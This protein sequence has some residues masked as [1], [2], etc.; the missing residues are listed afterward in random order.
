MLFNLSSFYRFFVT[1]R[2]LPLSKPSETVANALL[3]NK[4][5]G[6]SNYLEIYRSVRYSVI[7]I[8][9]WSGGEKLDAN[10]SWGWGFLILAVCQRT[11]RNTRKKAVHQWVIFLTACFVSLRFLRGRFPLHSGFCNFEV[12]LYFFNFWYKFMTFYLSSSS[13]HTVYTRV[14]VKSILLVS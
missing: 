9:G 6:T 8:R 3:S 11:N 7:L 10:H 12:R 5:N 14:F 2:L 4:L 1:F 13:F